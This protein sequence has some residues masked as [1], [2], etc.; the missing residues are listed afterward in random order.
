MKILKR[1]DMTELSFPLNSVVFGLRA[2][3]MMHCGPCLEL[4]GFCPPLGW[5]N[6]VQWKG[7]QSFAVVQPPQAVL[8]NLSGTPRFAFSACQCFTGHSRGSFLAMARSA[9]VALNEV[10]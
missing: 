6:V 9:S 1:V 3:G 5:F 2:G 7:L 4:L 10:G 8:E